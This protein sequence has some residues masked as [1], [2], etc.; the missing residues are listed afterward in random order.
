MRIEA[1]SL[2][3]G[4]RY[5]SYD[6]MVRY[7]KSSSEG[8]QS[9]ETPR[10]KYLAQTFTTVERVYRLLSVVDVTSL[11]GLRNEIGMKKDSEESC[12]SGNEKTRVETGIYNEQQEEE[13]GERN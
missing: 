7:R 3:D 6:G 1:H 9:R 4:D 5:R 2:C 13:S 12:D 8:V 10:K 11:M